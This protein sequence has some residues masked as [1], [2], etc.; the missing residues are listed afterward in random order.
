MKISKKAAMGISLVIGTVLF[1]TTAFAEVT[2]KSGYE[3]LK[4]AFKYTAESCNSKLQNYTI[5]TSI[6]LKDNG[7]V[8]SQ[9]DNVRK[10]DILK[11]A[12]ENTES[13]VEGTNAKVDSYYYSD[14]TGYI[15]YNS[16]EGIYHEVA[17]TKKSN[18]VFTDPFKEKGAG[19]IEKIVDAVVGNL[20][21]SVVVNQKSDGSNDLTGSI[22]EAQI[23]AVANALVSYESKHVFTRSNDPSGNK[24]MP[25]ITEDIYVKQVKGDVTLNKDGLIQSVIGTGVLSG[26]DD[27]GKVHELTFEILGKLVDV[28]STTV[29]KPDLTG[30]KV[31]E[32]QQMDNDILSNPQIYTGTYKNDIVIKKDNKFQKI[33]ERFVDIAH[34]DDKTIAGRYH[35]EYIKGYEEYSK[36]AR[37]F[38]FDAAIQKNNGGNATFEVKD[39]SGK[40]SQGNIYVGPNSVNVYFSFGNRDSGN[41]MDSDQYSRVFN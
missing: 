33:G 7:K 4:D 19:D 8:I 24:E 25:N 34:I 27:Q 16:T 14:K 6:V 1:T 15:S 2:S 23:P 11:G 35:E 40:T 38:K 20:K 9:Q 13:S 31:Q 30:K 3:E 17:V 5:N 29:N 36:N 37:D 18:D 26:K 32:D 10:Y 28:N 12:I 39:T 41:T 21:D 22:S